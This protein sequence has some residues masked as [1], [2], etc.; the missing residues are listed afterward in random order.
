MSTPIDP[1]DHAQSRSIFFGL[2]RYKQV[3]R[4]FGVSYTLEK[5]DDL[6]D[7][8]LSTYYIL[9]GPESRKGLV[10]SSDERETFVVGSTSD[11][12]SFTQCGHNPCPAEEYIASYID[13]YNLIPIYNIEWLHTGYSIS[14][15][16]IKLYMNLTFH[17]TA[18]ILLRS[19]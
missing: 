18:L 17:L 14:N 19:V 10:I 16:D 3:E 8:D 7:F 4:M 2:L 11:G 5:F 13:E 6:D 1:I 15:G 9:K 12:R